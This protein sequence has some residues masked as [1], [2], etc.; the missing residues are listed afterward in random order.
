MPRRKPGRAHRRLRFAFLSA[1]S[2][3]AAVALPIALPGG[4]PGGGAPA[5]VSQTPPPPQQAAGRLFSPTSFW[6]AALPADA[7]VDPESNTL[8]TALSSEVAEERSLG[9]G[10]WIQTDEATTPLYTVP[11]DQPT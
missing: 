8:V 3:A 11:P 4:G 2:A 6:N 5:P 1:A 7:A 9:T 10:P